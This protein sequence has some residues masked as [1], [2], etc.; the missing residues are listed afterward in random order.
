MCSNLIICFF[1]LKVT[2][3]FEPMVSA[4]PVLQR[5]EML[6]AGERFSKAQNLFGPISGTKIHTVTCK[7][8]RF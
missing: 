7:Q 6:G 4:I 5:L 8:S 3:N 2:T 1:S